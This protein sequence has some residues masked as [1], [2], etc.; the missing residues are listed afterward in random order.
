MSRKRLL[1]NIF[2]LGA[3]QAANY[4]LPLLILPYLAHVLGVEHL[5]LL[6]FAVAL[7]QI[8][9][10]LT[11]YGF[12]LSASRE[13]SIRRDEPEAL[14]KLFAA[15]TT[16]RLLFMMTGF[17]V[18]LGLINLVPKFEEHAWLFIAS[19]VLVVG[20]AIFPLWLFQGLERLKIA[21]LVQIASKLVSLSLVF[22]LVKAPEDVE[23]A[24][25]LQGA[26]SLLA[27]LLITP[28]I[29]GLIA[30]LKPAIPSFQDLKHQLCQGWHIF[31]STASINFYT[32]S[33]TFILGLIASP[34][35]VG[36]YHIAEKTIRAVQYLFTPVSQAVYPHV[37]R[38]AQQAPAAALAFNR[39][40]LVWA[41][42]ISIMASLTVFI[43]APWGVILVFG[44]AF[45]TSAGIL[46]ILAPLPFIIVL[47]NILGVQTMLSFNLKQD[48]SR[49]F[50]AASA[51][52]FVLFI[53]LAWIYGVHGAAWANVLVETIVTLLM[54]TTLHHKNLNPLTHR[55]AAQG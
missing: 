5:G 51:V 43:L 10:V 9:V 25:F 14:I 54:F 17:I 20:N 55:L 29:P 48:F 4:V 26:G 50:V 34:T 13:A 18:L 16:L 2:S 45:E 39:K 8:F 21:S 22:L 15:V 44:E 35:A 7:M 41:G 6:A 47:S 12:N 46:Q 31:I 32:S 3:L 27:A 1:E 42:G 28:W 24:A 19:Y 49:I 40:L 53:P 33:N 23:M 38:L 11:D 30:H 37:S 36:I 52:N